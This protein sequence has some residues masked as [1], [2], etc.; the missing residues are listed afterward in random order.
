MSE[1]L[2]AAFSL[3]HL[4]EAQSLIRCSS[5]QSSI[6]QHWCKNELLSVSTEQA[7][8]TQA[9]ATLPHCP[10]S[11]RQLRHAKT[12]I[13]T[14]CNIVGN[15]FFPTKVKIHKFNHLI[16]L[17]YIGGGATYFRVVK[18][19]HL[20]YT[21]GLITAVISFLYINWT[22][23]GNIPLLWHFNWMFVKWWNNTKYSPIMLLVRE[24][25][26]VAVC[27]NK[28]KKC[29]TNPLPSQTTFTPF[30]FTVIT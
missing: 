5:L 21:S 22:V 18:H 3:S 24:R 6:L 2:V 17:I 20:S 4:S 30:R 9:R 15:Y 13:Q 8:Q 16:S 19:D 28:M 11:R 27:L 1:A 23:T 7:I 14:S 29:Y 10:N 26:E 12:S 25:F